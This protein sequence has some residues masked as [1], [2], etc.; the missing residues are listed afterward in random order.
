MPEISRFRGIVVRMYV[1]VGQ[2]HHLAHFH[3]YHQGQEG[4][5][6]IAPLARIAGSLPRREERLV[7]NWAARHQAEL[8]SNW[9]RLQRG[10]APAKIV[11]PQSR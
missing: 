4:I 2:R 7:I 8:Q 1:E 3:A 5:C 11:P 6:S 9:D 10:R